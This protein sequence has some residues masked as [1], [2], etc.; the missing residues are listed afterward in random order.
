MEDYLCPLHH[1]FIRQDLRLE[2]M[3]RIALIKVKTGF[4][5]CMTSEHLERGIHLCVCN[6]QKAFIQ[7]PNMFSIY[8]YITG[9][10]WSYQERLRAWLFEVKMVRLRAEIVV[11]TM[12]S[13]HWCS[14]VTEISSILA[15]VI[16]CINWSR[17]FPDQ[18]SRWTCLFVDCH[19]WLL[20]S[21]P[22][23]AWIIISN[24]W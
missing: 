24:C 1:W 19:Y 15:L 20:R 12:I 7:P 11:M 2:A 10:R 3:A 18:S 21:M 23:H 6:H 14:Q 4:S 8:H 17:H 13:S 9:I 22:D 16:N 5:L